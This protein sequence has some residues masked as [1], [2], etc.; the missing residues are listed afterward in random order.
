[1]NQPRE[2]KVRKTDQRLKIERE[3]RRKETEK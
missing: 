2:R 1:M 3:K